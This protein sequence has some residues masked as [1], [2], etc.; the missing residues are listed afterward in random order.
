[1]RIMEVVADHMG[2]T[3]KSEIEGESII[4]I[5]SLK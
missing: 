1:M 2:S 5:Y 4:H 3:F